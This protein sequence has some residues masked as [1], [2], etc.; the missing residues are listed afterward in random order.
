MPSDDDKN[1]V[2]SVEIE[3]VDDQKSFI[4]EVD[5]VSMELSKKYKGSETDHD[6]IAES[7]KTHATLEPGLYW[8][9]PLGKDEFY[10]FEYQKTV[11]ETFKGRGDFYLFG[12][13]VSTPLSSLD[14]QSIQKADIETPDGE[15]YIGNL[16]YPRLKILT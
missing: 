13:N 6:A 16:T 1:V 12:W 4:D 14:N 2:E 15:K 5:K 3:I 10:L 9:K 11:D 8:A 7:K